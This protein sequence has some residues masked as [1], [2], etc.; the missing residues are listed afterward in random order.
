MTAVSGLP[1][2]PKVQDA[3]SSHGVVELFGIHALPGARVSSPSQR[4][5]YDS[6]K[7]AALTLSEFE[8]VARDVTSLRAYYREVQAGIRIRID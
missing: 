8:E 5:D 6:E 1:H 4:G 3:L 7:D 2:P